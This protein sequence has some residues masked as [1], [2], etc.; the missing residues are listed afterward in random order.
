MI[1]L[2]RI[3]QIPGIV[4]VT[5]FRHS[6]SAPRTFA[7]SF[8]FP[9]KCLFYTVRLYPLCCHYSVTMI[10]SRSRSFIKN[11]VIGS[12][13]ITKSSALGTMGTTVP[14]S[15]LQ[16]VLVILVLKQVSQFRCFGKWVKMLCLPDTTWAQGSEGNSW[17]DLEVSRCSGKLSSTRPC[18]NSCSQSGTSCNWSL[19]N[20]SLSSFLFGFS[21]SAGS[22]RQVSLCFHTRSLTSDCCWMFRGSHSFL[23]WRCGRS[24]WRWS[25]RT[26]R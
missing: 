14:V 8:Q 24:R 18:L 7:S 23:R 10:V 3:C 25:W 15:F 2:R 11:F 13:K 12:F 20:S 9:E 1:S 21:I 17:E 4:S 19:C 22:M 16:E 6:S 26:C 5:D